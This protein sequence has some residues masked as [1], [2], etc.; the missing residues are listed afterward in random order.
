MQFAK[1]RFKTHITPEQEK[2][3]HEKIAEK[4]II[5]IDIDKTNV[6]DYK[7]A[8]YLASFKG[9][10]PT[11]EELK[12]SGLSFGKNIKFM[13]PVRREDKKPDGCIIS[14]DEEGIHYTSLVSI[15]GNLPDDWT[16]ENICSS[17]LTFMYVKWNGK[18]PHGCSIF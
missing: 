3:M 1:K 15:V 13:N 18:D 17:P 2:E 14:E 9:E 10:L 16:F 11:L 7:T 6:I 5:R 12:E 8:V 4:G